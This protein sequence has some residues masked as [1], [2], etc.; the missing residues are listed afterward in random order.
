MESPP[1]PN[2][3]L[4]VKRLLEASRPRPHVNLVWWIG[5]MFLLVLLGTAVIGGETAAGKEVAAVLSALATIGL[6]AGVSALS[7]YTVRR[8]RAEQQ[9]VEQIGELVQLRRWP[10]AA[11]ALDQYLSQPARTQAFRV[12]ALVFLSSVLAR[13]QR[14]ED[15]IAVQDGLLQE[16]L[17]DPPSA[18]TV[19]VGRAM[20][21]LQEDHLFDADRAISELRRGP[22]AGSAGLALLELYRDVKTG[23]PA[24]AIELFEK[25]LPTLRDQLGHRVADAWALAARAY[26]LLGREDQARAAFRNATLLAPVTELFRRYP[27]VQKL[28]GRFQP[29][30]APPEAA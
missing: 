6:I 13:L 9:Q 22:A 24:E 1:A 17:L 27:E 7:V 23:H 28:G 18:A 25:M 19:R 14:F 5:G 3:L 4:D 26:D 11:L 29:S 2:G 8:F 12:Q 20:A 16:G 21:M 10:D 30:P 15:A